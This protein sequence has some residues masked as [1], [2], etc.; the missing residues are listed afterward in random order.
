MVTVWSALSLLCDLG[1]GVC[2]GFIAWAISYAVRRR[3]RKR[4]VP[5]VFCLLRWDDPDGFLCRGCLGWGRRDLLIVTDAEHAVL[6]QLR[7][8][9]RR[10]AELDPEPLA[11][12]ME[13]TRAAH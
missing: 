11:R 6:R 12:L 13:S 3:N 9:V 10:E 8:A 4:S 7:G 1:I 5:C 2:G